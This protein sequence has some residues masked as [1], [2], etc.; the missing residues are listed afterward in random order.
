MPASFAPPSAAMLAV[1]DFSLLPPPLVTAWHYRY[2]DSD[3]TEHEMTVS[4]T[5]HTALHPSST[6]H[7]SSD[8]LLR[9]VAVTLCRD[10]L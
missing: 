5:S 3:V 7:S 9:A 8:S 6:A 2:L 4:G 10:V 1:D